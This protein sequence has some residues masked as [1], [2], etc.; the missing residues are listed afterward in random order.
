M[1]LNQQFNEIYEKLNEQ[2]LKMKTD[3]EHEKS[4]VPINVDFIPISE[5]QSYSVSLKSLPLQS[6]KQ[7]SS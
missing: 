6:P 7:Q 5:E 4:G 1:L 2:V 3:R